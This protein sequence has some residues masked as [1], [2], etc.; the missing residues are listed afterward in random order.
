MAGESA[1]VSWVSDQLHELLG[2]SDKYIAEYLFELAKKTTSPEA[3][4]TKLKK[5][6]AVTVNDSMRSFAV[7]LWGKVPHKQAVEKPARAREREIV[8]QQLKNRSYR[9]LSDSEEEESKET[10]V[11]GG[12]RASSKQDGRAKKRRNIRT[13]KDSAWQSGSSE[14]EEEASAPA[15]KRK[16]RGAGESD[17]DEWE[18][19]VC[20]CVCVC[21][22]GSQGIALL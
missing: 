17:S 9:L 15:K 8:Q 21:V 14:E 22:T 4:V 3:Y 1:T 18:R 6:G 20:V 7:E 5:T 11:R 2:L 16:S 12:A 13:K 19:C 10:A